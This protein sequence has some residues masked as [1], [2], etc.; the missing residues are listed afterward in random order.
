MTNPIPMSNPVRLDDL[1]EA[2]KK[3]DVPL[4]PQ[5]GFSRFTPPPATW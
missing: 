4:D 3:A 1:I 5:Q 2:I